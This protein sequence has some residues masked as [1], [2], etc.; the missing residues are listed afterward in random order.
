MRVP[1][2]EGSGGR[3]VGGRGRW[4]GRGVVGRG[5]AIRESPLRGARREWVS[6][7]WVV[8]GMPLSPAPLDSCL[9]R[10]DATGEGAGMTRGC[11]GMTRGG[12]RERRVGWRASAGERLIRPGG[13][14]AEDAVVEAGWAAAAVS[15]ARTAYSSEASV[16]LPGCT[17]PWEICLHVSTIAMGRPIARKMTAKVKLIASSCLSNARRGSRFGISSPSPAAVSIKNGTFSNRSNAPAPSLYAKGG[18]R[19]CEGGNCSD[20]TIKTH[21]PALQ[22][23]DSAQDSSSAH[24]PSPTKTWKRK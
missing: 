1:W 7:G 10:N 12:G 2:G 24:R 13:H 21:E 5:G 23:M 18:S 11:A 4:Q 16:D 14:Y 17:L 22:E 6:R 19:Q 15:V 8:V 9:R 20:N 3:G